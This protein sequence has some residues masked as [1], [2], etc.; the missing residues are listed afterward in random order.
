MRGSKAGGM[1]F[2]MACEGKAGAVG[3]R[4]YE[5]TG[6]FAAGSRR[7]MGVCVCV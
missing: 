3:G 4:G 5:T 2:E 7:H 6:G 1:G